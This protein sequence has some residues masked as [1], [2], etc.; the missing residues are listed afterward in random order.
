MI[1]IQFREMEKRF[2][3]MEERFDK[4]E[5]KFD[6][7]VERLENMYGKMVGNELHPDGVVKELE[8]LKVKVKDLE[9]YK[10]KQVY[11]YWIIGTICS[12][13]GALLTLILFFL[14]T[15]K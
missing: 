3:E 13:V 2:D 8:Q 4:L 7:F 14:Q 9:D 12:F 6:K 11:S 10:A 15:F 1:E 5:V